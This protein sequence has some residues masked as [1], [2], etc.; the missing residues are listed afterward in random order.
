MS[1]TAKSVIQLQIHASEQPGQELPNWQG[2]TFNLMAGT[3]SADSTAANNVDLAAD[4][5]VELEL[6]DGSSILAAAED[7]GR[8]LAPGRGGA[9]ADGRLLVGN[10]LRLPG[11]AGIRRDGAGSWILKSL[12]VYRQGPAGMAAE[13]LA[14]TFQDKQLGHAPG[15]YRISLKQ[16]SM[17]PVKEMAASP[18]PCLLFL[19]GTASSCEGSF[20]AL[21]G[22]GESELDAR[23]ELETVYGDRVYG[24]EHRSLTE[25]P[26]A[27]VVDLVKTLPQGARLHVVS[28]SRGGML[29]ELLARAN[30]VGGEPFAASDI[31]RFEQAGKDSERSGYEQDAAR[32]AQLNNEMKTR[33]IQVERFVRVAA[34]ARGTTLASGRLDRWASIMLNLLGAGLK[35]LPG[36]NGV[37]PVYQALK[38]FLLQVVKERTDAR[39]LPGLEAMMP[40]SPLVGLLNAPEVAVRYPLHVIAGDYQ[41]D[42]FFSRLGDWLTEAFYGS[43]TDLVVNTPSMSGGAVR[44]GGVYLKSVAGPEVTHFTYFKRRE[45]AR[46][47]L[48]ALQGRNGD[49]QPLDE[50]SRTEI[51]RGGDKIMGPKRDMSNAP[52]VLMLPGIMGSQL[53]RDGEC[54]WF[55]PLRMIAGGME[56]LKFGAKV[57]A[58]GWI[59]QSYD[60]FAAELAK[61]YEV[62]PFVYDWRLSIVAAADLFRPVLKQALDDAKARGTSLRIVAHSMGGLVARLALK[63]HWE[64]L[65]KLPGSRLIQFGTPNLGSHS[66]AAVLT[67]RDDLVC[68]LVLYADWKHDMNEFLQIVRDFPGVLE[69]LPW[70]DDQVDYFSAATWS[71][72]AKSDRWNEGR[73][74]RSGEPYEPAAGAKDGW[75]APQKE[76]LQSAKAAVDAIK[77][78]PLPP[79]LTLYVAGRKRTPVGVRFRNGEMEIAWTEQGDGRVPW[80]TGIP[81]GVPTWYVD[82]AHGSLLAK[83][84]Y[85]EDYLS[86]LETGRCS[87]PSQRPVTRALGDAAYLPAPVARSGLY[88]TAA[89]VLNLALGADADAAPAAEALPVI[90]IDVVH[91][92]LANA[93]APVLAGCYANDEIKGSIAFLDKHL[94]QRLSKTLAAG[95]F[96]RQIGEAM[97]F[98]QTRSDMAP[99]GA[100]VVGL[101]TLGLLK[102][103]DLT[104]A[105]TQGLLEYARIYA[106]SVTGR[107]P[108]QAPSGLELSAIAVGTGY[109]GLSIPVAIRCLADALRHTQHS[110]EAAYGRGM[111]TLTK[112]TLYEDEE[113]RAVAAAETL[114]KLTAETKYASCLAFNGRIRSASGAYRRYGADQSGAGGWSQAHVLKGQDGGLRFTLVTDRARN[115]VD[116]E[117]SQRQAVDGLIY[118]ATQ[119]TGDKPGLSRALFELMV[120]N[121]FKESIANVSGLVMSMDAEAASYPWELMRDEA[122]TYEPPLATRIGL[123]RQLASVYGRGRVATVSENNVLLV[124]DT[125]SA[126]RY[127]VLLGA[128]EEAR[129]LEQKFRLKRYQPTPLICA[130]GQ[131]VLVKLLDGHY[132]ALHLATH[133]M[134]SED[135]RGY[136]GVVLGADT[137]LTPAQV[138]KLRRVPEIV[139]LNCC[140]LGSMAGDAK[141]RWG[142]LAANLATEFIEMGCKAVVAAGW[143]VDD[144]A[145]SAF[146]QE[147]WQAMLDGKTFGDAVRGARQQIFQSF[148]GCNTWGA[149]QAYGDPSYVM[150]IQKEG[151]EE[152]ADTEERVYLLK[153]Q[154]RADLEKLKAR[155]GPCSETEKDYYRRRLLKI[156]NAAQARFYG[157]GALRQLLAETWLAIDTSHRDKAIEH[158]RAAIVQEDGSA[159]LKAVEQLAN[160]EIRL[161][162]DAKFRQTE[163][164]KSKQLFQ[165]AKAR[166]EALLDLGH[167]Q[168]RIS[169]MASYFKHR[170]MVEPDGSAKAQKLLHDMSHWYLASSELSLQQAGDRDYYPT[171]NYLDGLL[172]E[173]T[174]GPS[175]E[176]DG[177]CL[178]AYLEPARQN[179]QRRMLE[180]GGLGGF[181]HRYAEVDA[182]RIDMLWQ[183]AKSD[184]P[185][186]DEALQKLSDAHGAVFQV[187]G[188]DNERN[189]V[190]KQL[191]WLLKRMADGPVKNSLTSWKAK[192]RQG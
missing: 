81:A 91:G 135:G 48:N 164:D 57:S 72:W 143:A 26:I 138:S 16:W 144:A 24:F 124:G 112:I 103:G 190:I 125:D 22:G 82:A 122:E 78:A 71:D 5:V 102:P 123:V 187:L 133:G 89:E 165:T 43:G 184:T 115:E 173:K 79:D 157:D 93:Q 27:N 80:A 111:R 163:P 75:P 116:E 180:E 76:A 175:A 172:L 118:S 68:N 177:L 31:A 85:F 56:K 52:I 45:S 182:Q 90:T 13:A 98:R 152:D 161:A 9:A 12:H 35:C 166:L 97:V 10:S 126:G 33:G 3:R 109:A 14:G 41:G 53:A 2:K 11:A 20:R 119:D 88:P 100:I 150:A 154:V 55:A 132:R 65:R 19:H 67:G 188:G 168:E 87:L 149:Y 17:E 153:G 117:P 50:P 77:A 192:I 28:H 146:A 83:K 121:S 183:A 32:L 160:Q 134:V 58:V 185:A 128:Q 136:T 167:T 120:P 4:D 106:E 108:A 171:L 62:R 7:V 64:A 6:Q 42:G 158:Y 44:S 178:S 23:A 18:E 130:E 95:R 63:D 29:G 105:L 21:W 25:S 139:F 127:P 155:I 73:L 39:V 141:P 169:L 186:S 30:R 162:A 51:A 38:S 142:E 114:I 174:H 99:G 54:I 189:S 176:F 179:A 131:D 49:F 170:E 86:L 140:H 145:A 94:D 61:K 36:I 156:E 60:D 147:F 66:I 107:A 181:F 34:T 46:P 113:S 59:D 40:D 37:S 15:L 104:M 96:P 129:Q 137:Y 84:K 74:S 148:P 1:D 191:D 70:Q 110:L 47:L 8:Y 69:L 151:E 159:G 92:S 101:G